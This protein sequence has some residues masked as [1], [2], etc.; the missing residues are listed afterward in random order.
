M[1]V[2][3]NSIYDDILRI[4]KERVVVLN[5]TNLVAMD[6]TAN[7]LLALG[8][9]PIMSQSAH[10]VE[11]LVQLAQSVSLN[12]GTLDEA[13]LQ[14]A[15]KALNHANQL[16]RPVVLDPVGAGATRLRTGAAAE[17]IQSAKLTCVRANASECIALS[18][19]EAPAESG[20]VDAVHSVASA[21]PA[22]H[23]LVE[24]GLPCVAI[25]G[26]VDFVLC[27]DAR[28]QIRNGHPW[29]TQV[30]AMGCT[31]SSLVAA[32]LAVN[33]NPGVAAAHAMCVMGICGELAARKT[34]GPGTF[35]AAFL[36]Q[37]H[38]LTLSDLEARLACESIL[39]N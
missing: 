23:R 14:L 32:F 3:P 31:A 38:G 28:L 34:A 36:D 9:S 7:A 15:W 39:L 11:D 10:E 1:K 5:I 26:S 35:R 22:A 29:M 12:M 30:T 21:I 2:T 19:E 4:R 25:S 27:H 8:A 13:W 18:P 37:L 24:Q 17:L 33:P 20:G 16:R 6:L